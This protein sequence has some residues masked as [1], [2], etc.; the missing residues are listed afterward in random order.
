MRHTLAPLRALIVMTHPPSLEGGA[1][2]RCAVAL[3]EGLAAR[4][5]D[6][7]VLCPR[8]SGPVSIPAGLSVEIAPGP[9]PRLAQVRWDRLV[10]PLGMLTRGPFTERLRTISRDVDVVH[11]VEAEAASVI[12]FVDRPA[13][14][15]LHC[16]TRRDP[17]VWNPLRSAGRDSIELLR[18]EIRARRRA[19]WLLVNS[20]EVGRPLEA[21]SPHA[22]VVVAPLALDPSHYLQRATLES[23]AA[24]LIG[25]A[26]WPPTAEAVERLLTRVWPLVL[27]RRPE[28]RLILAGEGMERSAFGHLP[29][30]PGVEWRGRVASATDLLREL[31]VL[32]YPLT[33]GSGAKVKVIE[34]LAL[35]IPVVTTPEGAE[36]IGAR[37]GLVVESEDSRL[38]ESLLRLCEDGQ[39]RRLAGEAAYQTFIRHH[40]PLPA[41]APVL[42][43]YERM[44]D[45]QQAQ[46]A[47][48]AES[49]R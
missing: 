43:L 44:V 9:E 8:S 24:G 31:G 21:V 27:Q 37:G 1:A 39:A 3:L 25:T 22:E 46:V 20:I 10:R 29:E 41:A 48:P 15:Q 13:V 23:S 49:S 32:L 5:V 4:G 6:C 19:R 35:G 2:A 47:L 17:R 40:A 34:A 16:L 45:A 14:V 30:L 36:G 12:Q 7:Q 38:V 33:A 26:R 11:F 18:G 42:E 28:A